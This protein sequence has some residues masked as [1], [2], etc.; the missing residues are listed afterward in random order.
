LLYVTAKRKGQL[1]RRNELEELYLLFSDKKCEPTDE[2]RRQFYDAE[3]Y[4]NL[5]QTPDPFYECLSVGKKVFS[6]TQ[7]M[8]RD[9]YGNWEW[10]GWYSYWIDWKGN[11]WALRHLMSWHSDP[12]EWLFS[13]EESL[14]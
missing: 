4:G 11:R 13:E 5:P 6:I 8:I 3:T 9:S 2:G 1:K 14:I 10:C 12:P 7:E